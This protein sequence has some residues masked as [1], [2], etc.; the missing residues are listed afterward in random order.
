MIV[1]KSYLLLAV[2][3]LVAIA[4]VPAV[5]F[6][7]A[8]V[9]G[10]YTM[11]TDACAGCHR[12]HTAPST[13]T[14]VDNTLT[15]QSALLLSD[16]TS[17]EEFCMTCHDTAGQGAETNVEGG[18]YNAEIGGLY[19]TDGAPLNGGAFGR[20]ID[21]GINPPY[22]ADAN[23]ATVTSVHSAP[24]GWTIFGGGAFG[25][26]TSVNAS[27]GDFGLPNWGGPVISYLS[28]DTCH[29]VH[30]AANYRILKDVVWGNTVGG[31]DP[32]SV[33]P[34]DPDPQPYVVSCEPGFP[35]GGFRLHTDYEA[36]GY[37][38]DYTT[39]KY[40]KPADGG[41]YKGMVGWCTGCHT[42][43]AHD[44]VATTYSAGDSLFWDD[45]LRHRHPQNVPLSNWQGPRSIIVS[46]SPLPFANDPSTE[47]TGGVAINKTATDWIECLT[48]HRAHGTTAVMNGYANVADSHNPAVD[49]GLGG[50]PPDTGSGLLRLDNRGVCE[51]C[52]NK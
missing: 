8:G 15:E 24:G 35:I 51:E 29:D 14:W 12:A 52:H 16:A 40:A 20:L 5:A 31:Y 37:V 49:T 3:A 11:D 21:D 33:D 23:D 36:L 48:C 19:G 10:N 46:S 45:T 50:V 34:E 25:T 28:C 30:G 6:G 7:N 41:V 13:I 43:Y 38:P 22:R 39:P 9:H 17:V 4:V 32:A 1:K 47:G 27:G 42:Q 2:V 44:T 18:V 26:T